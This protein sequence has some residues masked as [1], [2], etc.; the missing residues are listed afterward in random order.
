V[1]IFVVDRL[2]RRVM[3]LED[4]FFESGTVNPI[5]VPAEGLPSGVYFVRFVGETFDGTQGVT[6]IR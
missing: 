2:G 3:M 6:V 4:R 5:V 1:V